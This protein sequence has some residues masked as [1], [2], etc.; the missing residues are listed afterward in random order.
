MTVGQKDG[1]VTVT[2]DVP[3]VEKVH[4]QTLGNQV[5]IRSV[6][7]RHLVLPRAHALT[8]VSCRVAMA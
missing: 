3:G 6:R 4:W 1:K 2:V 5:F 7:R 8:R